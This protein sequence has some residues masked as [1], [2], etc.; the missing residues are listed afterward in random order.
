MGRRSLLT[1]VKQTVFHTNNAYTRAL[2]K[3]E[4]GVIKEINMRKVRELR[5]LSC[6]CL[7]H[8][9]ANHKGFHRL[10]KHPLYRR[11]LKIKTRCYNKNNPAYKNYGGRGV[12][13][14]QEWLSDPTLF[15]KWGLENG[16]ED[17]LEIDKDIKS[18]KGCGGLLYSPD[19]C[20]F[21]TRK[22]N[23]NAR[24]SNVKYELNGVIRNVKEWSVVTGISPSLIRSRIKILK[25]NVSDALTIPPSK[26]PGR[27]KLMTIQK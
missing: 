20:L 25:W 18:E 2:Y 17:G 12:T 27:P 15:V 6:G 16:W 7:I 8:T 19:T 1:L 21:V 13:I 24:R 9:L 23:C 22:Q 26:Q 4:C 5:T 11:F 3:C 14:C 10:S